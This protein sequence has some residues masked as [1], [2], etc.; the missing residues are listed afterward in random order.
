M[1]S[2]LLGT[3]S[4]LCEGKLPPALAEQ[5]PSGARR[6][7]WL[8]GRTLLC[9]A[10][11]PLPEIIYGSQGKPTF[12]PGTPLWF[13]LSHS[14]DT[15]VLLLSDEGEVGCDLE[16]VRP[17]ENWPT[18]AHAVFTPQERTELETKP[19]NEQLAAFWQIWTRKEAIIKQ[20]GGSAWLMADIDSTRQTA[21]FVSHR[22]LGSL[23]LSICTPTPVNC[24]EI[25][26]QWLHVENGKL[27]AGRNN[28]TV[29]QDGWGTAE[30][31]Q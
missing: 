4:E 25:M 24:A 26:V 15:I 13:N 31:D 6:A 23:S 9:H 19:S 20:C 16:V 2:L 27:Y 29:A 1:Y 21:P 11:A 22:W 18:L 3:I 8:A 30:L 28:L 5:A 17:R 7:S 10:R 12:S 14:G